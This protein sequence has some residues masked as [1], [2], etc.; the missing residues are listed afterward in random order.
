MHIVQKG[1]VTAVRVLLVDTADVVM[2]P[3]IKM[4]HAK[5]SQTRLYNTA[6]FK[7]ARQK[8]LLFCNYV[9]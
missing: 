7:F 5:V 9:F 6:T 2:E 8:V 3:L 4:A 1:N